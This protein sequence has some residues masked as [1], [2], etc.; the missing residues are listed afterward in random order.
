MALLASFGVIV[1]SELKVRPV[2]PAF[3]TEEDSKR[4]GVLTL[5]EILRNTL[6]DSFTFPGFFLTEAFIGLIFR[7]DKGRITFC[8]WE[9]SYIEITI[10]KKKKPF[11]I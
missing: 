9:V 5:G 6:E 1:N 4:L 8:D 11:G 3:L 7:A 2:V 10:Y